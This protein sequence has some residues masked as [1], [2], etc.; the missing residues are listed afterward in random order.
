MPLFYNFEQIYSQAFSLLCLPLAS[1]A[2]NYRDVITCAHRAQVLGLPVGSMAAT[3]CSWK[4]PN[5]H[6]IGRKR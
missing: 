6:V 5:L 4:E 1:L 3:E 2:K